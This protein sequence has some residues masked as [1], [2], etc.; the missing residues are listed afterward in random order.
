MFFLPDFSHPFLWHRLVA[1]LPLH[2]ESNFGSI[3][4]SGR[5]RFAS[6]TCP[7]Q[8]LILAQKPSCYFTHPA[9]L[10][11]AVPVAPFQH[12]TTSIWRDFEFAFFPSEQIMLVNSLAQTKE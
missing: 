11:V 1:L 4:S 6:A 8:P 12:L 3:R 9:C 7:L 5:D 10:F 2:K